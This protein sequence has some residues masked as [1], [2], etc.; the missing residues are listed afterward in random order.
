MSEDRESD[1]T[2]LCFSG[3][4]EDWPIWSTQFLALAQLKKFKRSLLGLEVPPS[5]YVDLDEDS[6][7]PD[8]KKRVESKDIK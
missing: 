8:T 1:Y 7:D 3:K 6:S 2:K 4:K 5:E